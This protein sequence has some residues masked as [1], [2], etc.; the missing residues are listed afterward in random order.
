MSKPY[1][2]NEFP[3]A[4]VAKLGQGFMQSAEAEQQPRPLNQAVRL[5]DQALV[6]EK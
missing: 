4:P 5:P 1:A 3:V 6:W 2:E